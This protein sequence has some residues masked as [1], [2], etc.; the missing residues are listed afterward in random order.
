MTK[1]SE[2]YI[3]LLKEQFNHQVQF[4]EKRPGIEQLIAPLYHEDG[5]IVDIYLE[6]SPSDKSKIRICDFGMSL[7]RLSYDFEV[8]TPH[9]EKVFEKLLAENQLAEEG[10][11]NIY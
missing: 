3:S 7:M 9:K 11:G 5:D 1:E 4:R 2:N 6:Q 10:D 8:D